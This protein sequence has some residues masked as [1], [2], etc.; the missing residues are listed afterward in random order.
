M[1]GEPT[2]DK[3]YQYEVNPYLID[4][5]LEELHAEEWTIWDA[6]PRSGYSTKHIRSLGFE[7]ID[8]DKID[9]LRCEVLPEVKPGRKLLVLLVPPLK[10]KRRYI[11]KLKILKAVHVALLLPTGTVSH[12]YFRNSFPQG[13]NQLIVHQLCSRFLDPQTFKPLR[14]AS[15]T[16]MWVTVGLGL[17]SDILYK[18]RRD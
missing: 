17:R 9:F 4:M 2:Q 8:D 16:S 13:S 10:T 15:F 11:E 12:D 18:A 3:N 14:N 5:V 7:V 6:F 1:G